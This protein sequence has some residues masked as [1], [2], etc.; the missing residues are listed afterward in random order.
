LETIERIRSG[1]LLMYHVSSE[2]EPESVRFEKIVAVD[3]VLFPD[4]LNL[5]LAWKLDKDFNVRTALRGSIRTA[6]AA[7]DIELD[8]RLFS[9]SMDGYYIGPSLSYSYNT[10]PQ[11]YLLDR[12]LSQQQSIDFGIWFGNQYL[13]SNGF[14]ANIGAGINRI[15]RTSPYEF[16]SYGP[17]IFG[18]LDYGAR[19]EVGYA[20]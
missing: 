11:S 13:W 2:T 16:G 15:V 6:G 18:M 14:A 9:Q 1:A 7:A 19:V 12:A 3:P 5:S 17:S 20:W 10:K 8:Y 4:Y